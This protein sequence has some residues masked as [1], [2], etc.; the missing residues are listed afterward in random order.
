M[1]TCPGP[2]QATLCSSRLQDTAWLDA[3]RCRHL[4][5]CCCSLQADMLVAARQ[6][7]NTCLEQVT[8]WDAFMAALSNKHMVLA[9]W[10][11]EVAVSVRLLCSCVLGLSL[12]PRLAAGQPAGRQQ[13][14]G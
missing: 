2:A 14:D 4:Y 6:R 1:L 9:P 12:Q 13:G 11:D 3:C 8:S 10:A 5:C 7:Y